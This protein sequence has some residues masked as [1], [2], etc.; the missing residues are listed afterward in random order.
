MRDETREGNPEPEARPAPAG[1]GRRAERRGA[2]VSIP[3]RAGRPALLGPATLRA[4]LALLRPQPV[5][6]RPAPGNEG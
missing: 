6:L 3:S 1:A 2:K 5:T 4:R